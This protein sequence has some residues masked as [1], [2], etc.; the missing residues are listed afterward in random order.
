MCTAVRLS[1]AAWWTHGRQ[2]HA[3]GKPQCVRS[4]AAYVF[5][6]LRPLPTGLYALLM[7]DAILLCPAVQH[8]HAHYHRLA[9]IGQLFPACPL[10]CPARLLKYVRMCLG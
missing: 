8:A 9:P 5:R 7:S 3:A 2:G 4:D 1:V 10:L 6:K